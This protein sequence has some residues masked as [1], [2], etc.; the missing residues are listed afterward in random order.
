MRI[1]KG[2]YVQVISGTEAGKKGKVLRIL[3]K[4][5]RVVVEG[6]NYVKKHIKKSQ[7]HPQGGRIEIEASLH[8][9]NVVL[10]SPHLQEPTRVSYK[11]E[12]QGDDDK[13]K[14]VK[15]RYCKKSGRQL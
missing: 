2:D 8:V 9:S 6:V 12:V 4:K 15:V 3:T 7:K 5:D 13:K 11:Y 1:K 14:R 10:F